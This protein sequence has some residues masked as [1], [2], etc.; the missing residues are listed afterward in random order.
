MRPLASILAAAGIFAATA[1]AAL[2]G[3]FE[4]G[5]VARIVEVIDGD[6]VVLDTGKQDHPEEPPTEA[7]CR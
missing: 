5:G 2:A 3:P 4:P 6:T 1:A 7:R